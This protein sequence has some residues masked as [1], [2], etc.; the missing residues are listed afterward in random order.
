MGIFA[1]FRDGL[2]ND[3]NPFGAIVVVIGV[4]LGSATWW[5]LL[6][7]GVSVVRS[8]FTPGALVW[9]NRISG[10]VI[11]AFALRYSMGWAVIVAMMPR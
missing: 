6:S 4:F 8:R 3:S 7:G 11:C 1:G 9:V 2:L 10:A 5:L